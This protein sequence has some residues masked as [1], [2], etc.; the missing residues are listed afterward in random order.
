MGRLRSLR[1]G[2]GLA[3]PALPRWDGPLGQLEAQHSEV[4]L[5]ADMAKYSNNDFINK[6]S[7][8][9]VSHVDYHVVN[10]SIALELRQEKEMPFIGSTLGLVSGRRKS[11]GF[12]SDS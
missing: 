5:P 10:F 12:S 9:M 4:Y 3:V 6:K 7:D 11:A 2:S 1:V 8:R